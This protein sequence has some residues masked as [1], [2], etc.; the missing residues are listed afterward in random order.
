MDQGT[1]LLVLSDN[2]LQ[3]YD[4]S[5]PVKFDLVNRISLEE[6]GGNL[7]MSDDGNTLFISAGKRG[8][9]QVDLS[10]PA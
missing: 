9:Y 6:S 7:T 1:L 4:V 8:I 3:V 5:S 10:N 2:S